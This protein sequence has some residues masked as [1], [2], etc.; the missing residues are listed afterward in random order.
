MNY[1]SEKELANE[2]ITDFLEKDH[3]RLDGLFKNFQN[4][5]GSNYLRAKEYFIQFRFGLKRHII[6]EEE[7]LFPIFEDKTGIYDCGPTK[8]MENEHRQIGELVEAIHNKVEK[9]DRES[10][11]EER[12]LVGLLDLH[13]LREQRILY[14][15]IDRMTNANEKHT[16]FSK[17]QQ[18]ASERYESYE[19]A[20]VDPKFW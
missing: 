11:V 1:V 18:I 20:V 9:S 15:A 4:L 14:P 6:W 3:D 19:Y 7:V 13:N 12:M 8:I 10:D 17:I 16:L 2:T 5:K